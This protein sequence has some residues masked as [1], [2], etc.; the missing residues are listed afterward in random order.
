MILFVQCKREG[1]VIFVTNNVYASLT[2]IKIR[3]YFI[4]YCYKLKILNDP[5]IGSHR[6]LTRLRS[7][8]W[9]IGNFVMIENI[10]CYFDSLKFRIDAFIY[11]NVQRCN[12]MGSNVIVKS[13]G[14]DCLNEY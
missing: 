14:V 12:Y 2:V 10:L 5:E 11:N 1:D 9:D 3:F 6:F 4:L 8:S 7:F 13:C